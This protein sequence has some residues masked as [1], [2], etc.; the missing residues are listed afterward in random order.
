MTEQAPQGGFYVNVYLQDR[1]YGGPEEGGWWYDFGIVEKSICLPT[2]KL[3]RLVR[4]SINR[5]LR[6]WNA[7]RRSDI[8]SVISEGRYYCTVESHPAAD[9]PEMRP[10]YE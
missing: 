1:A 10:F 4:R 5:V 3:A 2:R 6:E 8:S 7:R 9:W